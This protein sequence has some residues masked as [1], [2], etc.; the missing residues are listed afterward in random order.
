VCQRAQFAIALLRLV[1]RVADERIGL[2]VFVRERL[3]SQL[4]RHDRLHQPLLGAVV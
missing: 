1:E 4:E 3:L 2:S